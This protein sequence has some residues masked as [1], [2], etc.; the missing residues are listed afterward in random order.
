MGQRV[1]M[2]YCQKFVRFNSSSISQKITSSTSFC[3]VFSILSIT[4]SKTGVLMK[5]L[6]KNWWKRM[7]KKVPFISS[8]LSFFSSSRNTL[9]KRSMLVHSARCS[10]TERFTLTIGSVPG[11]REAQSL[12]RAQS[13][14]TERQRKHS[15]QKS[16]LSS[17]GS[18]ME[19]KKMAKAMRMKNQSKSKNPKRQRPKRINVLWLSRK[20]KSKQRRW[21]LRD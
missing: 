7:E 9:S 18:N 3:A 4:L 11:M 20:R 6:S 13:S 5:R 1:S 10:M 12:T 19:K 15:R 16:Q 21:K 17:N 14:M 2:I 8:K